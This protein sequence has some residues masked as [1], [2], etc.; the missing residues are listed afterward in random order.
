MGTNQNPQ[1]MQPNHPTT[2]KDSVALLAFSQDSDVVLPKNNK[3]LGVLIRDWDR[4]K[5]MVGHCKKG[6]NQMFSNIAYM[7]FGV[8]GSAFLSLITTVFTRPFGNNDTLAA[9]LF[10]LIFVGTVGIGYLCLFF[11]TKQSEHYTV[12]I[13]NLQNEM[14]AMEKA[15]Q[16]S[17]E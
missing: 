12:S 15:A 17:N 13:E 3:Y 1:G 11:Q 8:S 9:I 5:V 10:I 4:L 2:D 6:P 14:D 7:L 16:I